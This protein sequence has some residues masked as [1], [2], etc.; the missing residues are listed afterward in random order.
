MPQQTPSPQDVSNQALGLA[1][2]VDRACRTGGRYIIVLDLPDPRHQPWAVEIH[3]A[4]L[5]RRQ[6]LSRHRP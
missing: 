2:L 6:R 3:G 4:D 5:L 1:R